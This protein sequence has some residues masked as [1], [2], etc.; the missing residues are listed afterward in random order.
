MDKDY[1]QILG[2][3]HAVTPTEIKAA[4]RRLARIYHPDVNPT[5]PQ[6]AAKIQEIIE[7]YQVLGE[8]VQRASYDRQCGYD[9]D[10]PQPDLSQSTTSAR[11]AARPAASPRMSKRAEQELER[12]ITRQIERD[13]SRN[14]IIYEV[15]LTGDMLW[16]EAEALVDRIAAKHPRSG[17]MWLRILYPTSLAI[18]VIFV[19]IAA[20]IFVTLGISASFKT[21]ERDDQV[22]AGVVFIVAVFLALAMLRSLEDISD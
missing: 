3:N 6:A 2:V 19:V 8:P 11:P 20:G 13:I 21:W 5:D 18:V 4:F 9:R 15:C 1:Y 12:F 17:P 16:Y 14:D 22:V 10:A 7:A